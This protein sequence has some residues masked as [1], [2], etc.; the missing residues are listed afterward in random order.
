MRLKSEK[1][2]AIVVWLAMVGVSL[3]AHLNL[4]DG[5]MAMHFRPDGVANGYLPRDVGLLVLPGLA[6]VLMVLLLWFLPAI[7]PKNASIDRSGAAYGAVMT[8]VLGLL[9]VIHVMLVMSAKGVVI[10]H[11]KVV[12]GGVGILLIV[13][14]NYLPKTRLNYLMGIRTPWTLSDERVWDRTH[15]FAGPLFV[16]GGLMV[17]AGVFLLPLPQQLVV[18][19]VA[20]AGPA[21]VSVVYSY[22][23]AKKLGTV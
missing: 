16:L 9:L 11:L 8:A 2:I 1:L 5:P 23:S 10:D 7:M 20:I 18:M 4:P 17:L 15:R 13:I 3:W 14:G 12:H 21:L 6:L 19:I 22:L